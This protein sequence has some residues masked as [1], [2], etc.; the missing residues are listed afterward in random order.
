MLHMRY[1]SAQY[2]KMVS[3]EAK[4]RGPSDSCLAGMLVLKIS[5]MYN[6]ECIAMLVSGAS[7]LSPPY[8]IYIQPG[9]AGRDVS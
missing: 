9:V 4:D 5:N 2:L 3:A 1:S 7:S 6:S 8:C